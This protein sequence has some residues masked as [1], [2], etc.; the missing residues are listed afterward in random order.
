MPKLAKIES[1]FWLEELL[2]QTHRCCP[3]GFRQIY[4]GW[5]GKLLIDHEEKFAP[6]I[7]HARRRLEKGTRAKKFQFKKYFPQRS[8]CLRAQHGNFRRRC[9]SVVSRLP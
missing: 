9:A 4:R 6:A 7:L 3:G 1:P 5:G 8:R 2:V